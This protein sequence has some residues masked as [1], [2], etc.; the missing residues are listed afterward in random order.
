MEIFW[1][2]GGNSCHLDSIVNLGFPKKLKLYH[3]NQSEKGK[4]FC[5]EDVECNLGN[6]RGIFEAK[7]EE[8]C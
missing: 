3:S 7:G 6:L 2:F 8:S 4:D 1:E 5:L